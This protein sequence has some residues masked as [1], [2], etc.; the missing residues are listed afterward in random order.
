MTVTT[1][2]T[3]IALDD[4]GAELIEALQDFAR[5]RSTKA[6][7]R[8]G[9]DSD[10]RCGMRVPLYKECRVDPRALGRRL[11]KLMR[12]TIE[13]GEPGDRAVI[14]FA[15]D[16]DTQLVLTASAAQVSERDALFVEGR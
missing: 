15:K 6:L 9:E 14:E 10:V 7:V 11:R 13:G 8:H 2:T 5:S 4:A 3:S 1:Q 12:E 16:G